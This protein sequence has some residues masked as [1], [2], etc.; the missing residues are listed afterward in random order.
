M[1][2]E[3][4]GAGS[5]QPEHAPTT[6]CHPAR[7]TQFNS[8]MPQPSRML[9]VGGELASSCRPPPARPDGA[10]RGFST[11]SG[12][13]AT[14]HG[15]PL[16]GPM[17]LFLRRGSAN[18]EQLVA[19]RMGGRSTVSFQRGGH[20]QIVE[21]A[22]LGNCALRRFG[23]M[24]IC[25]RPCAMWTCVGIGAVLLFVSSSDAAANVRLNCGLLLSV[26]LSISWGA[27]M[28]RGQ[29]MT[30]SAGSAGRSGS[31]GL[32]IPRTAI[33]QLSR[34]TSK[35]LGAPLALPSVDTIREKF[36]RFVQSPTAP[37]P[38]RARLATGLRL[39]GWI[40]L[41]VFQRAYVRVHPRCVRIAL[42]SETLSLLSPSLSGCRS[43][44]LAHSG[45]LL[46]CLVSAAR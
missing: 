8:A 38:C 35:G 43:T 5:A 25:P 11:P 19:Q 42:L 46:P 37:H 45:Q 2:R 31:K 17:R 9:R 30:P 6:A 1:G 24:E 20:C 41:Y 14:L 3:V 27:C 40:L 7:H 15:V 39:W 16:L 21:L 12:V 23:F 36:M 34:E 10:L 18:G 28:R 4:P 22:F 29:R 32:G 26:V 44:S 33:V 13:A